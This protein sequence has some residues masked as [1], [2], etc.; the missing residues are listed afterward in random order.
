[1]VY[2]ASRGKTLLELFCLQPIAS[3][4]FSNNIL[5][6]WE[7]GQNMGA[8]SGHHVLSLH[9]KVKVSSVFQRT[10]QF[11]NFS[12]LKQ[13][14]WSKATANTIILVF[15]NIS[16]I[17]CRIYQGVSFNYHQRNV[18]SRVSV[19]AFMAKSRSR[20]FSQVSVLE[21]MVSTT[22]LLSRYFASEGKIALED[23]LPQ[24][25]KQTSLKIV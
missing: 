1:M 7:A 20:S 25:A 2:F 9:S 18:R 19:L 5:Q 23:I 17:F 13:I 10:R 14:Y 21:V 11:T 8:S 6:Y 16:N 12:E 4:K 22:L 15:G 3:T 24:E